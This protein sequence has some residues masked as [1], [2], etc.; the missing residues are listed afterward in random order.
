MVNAWAKD[1]ASWFYIGFGLFALAVALTGFSTTYINPMVRRTFAAPWY[2]HLHGA[3]CLA[4]VLLLIAQAR[5]VRARRTP[6]HRRLGQAALPVA[7][8]VWAAGIATALWAARRDFAEQGTAATSSLG[9]TATGLSVFL[10]LVIAA[11]ATRRRPDWH[12]RLIL[13]ATIQLLWPAFFRLRHLMPGIPDPDVWLAFV[14]A[15]SPIVVAAVRDLRRCGRI[16]PVWLY[17]APAM[18]FEQV[19]EFIRFDKWPMRE[20]GARLFSVLA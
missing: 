16:H 2:V 5:L 14:A 10:L 6:L 20:I 15:Y 9:G 12:K 11:L 8:L 7:L 4:W 19:V 17:V 3:A 1:R 18:V 13:L